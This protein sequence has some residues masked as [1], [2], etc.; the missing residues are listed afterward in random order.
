[1]IHQK[2]GECKNA[3]LTPRTVK[4]EVSGVMSAQWLRVEPLNGGLRILRTTSPLPGFSVVPMSRYG[5]DQ[6]SSSEV[7][8]LTLS[9]VA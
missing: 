8:T 2:V 3:D 7:A 9:L 1:M 5:C 4:E 6:M